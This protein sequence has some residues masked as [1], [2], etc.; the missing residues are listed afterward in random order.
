MRI[1][2]L[3]Q[4]TRRSGWA[5]V[6][7]QRQAAVQASGWF[8]SDGLDDRGKVEAFKQHVR[9]LILDYEPDALV[10]EKPLKVISRNQGRG[11][12]AHQLI[13]TRLDEVLVG[14]A[15]DYDLYSD[16]VAPQTWRALVLGKGSGNLPGRAAKERA[17]SYVGW[18]G[19]E[20][21][22]DDVA[23]AICIGL[24]AATCSKVL[25]ARTG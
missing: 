2:A 18:L 16:S 23:E 7:K 4:S 3:D 9:E 24:W 21:S 22:N 1:L 25:P 12:N 14:L 11:I 5:L 17:R 8:G 6:T 13:L 10:W 20:A 15:G 19:I